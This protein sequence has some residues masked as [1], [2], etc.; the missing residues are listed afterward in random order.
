MLYTS[1]G[2]DVEMSVAST[3][4]FYAQVAAGFLLACGLAEVVGAPG[5]EARSDLLRGLRELPDAMQAVLADAG[6]SPRP[7]SGS[8]PPGGTG[9]S[10]ATGPTASRPRRLRIKLSELCYKSI[11]CD[12]TEDKKHIDLSSEP[13]ILVCAAG[14]SGST[15]DDVAKEVAIY[16]AHKAAPIVIATDGDER[17]AAAQAVISV[18]SVHPSLA[19]VLS[20]MAGHLFGYEAALAIDAQA[21]PL[22]EAR[23]A[24]EAA[25]EAEVER[26]RAALVAHAA[27]RA[28]R[29]G[30]SSTGCARMPTTGT[31]RRAPRCGSHRSCGTRR[32]PCRSTPTRWSTASRHA[33]RRHRGPQQALTRAVEELTRPVDAIKHQAKTVTVGISRSDETLLAVPLVQAVLAAG[34]P[35]DRLGYRT[36]RTLAALDPAIDAVIGFT[37][38]RIDGDPTADQAIIAVVDRGGIGR[39]LAS[40]TER[41]PR[42]RGT[43]RRVAVEREVMA[44]RG[45]S[46]GRTLVIVPEVK[47]SD[48]TGITLLHV[49]WVD[50]LPAATARSV[51]QGYGRYGA[52]VDAVTE[53]EPT[54]RDDLLGSID[55]VDL[56]TESIQR[57]ADRWRS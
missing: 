21:R 23:A 11:A 36:L 52:L 47:G 8:R 35:R 42:L 14:L 9:R 40:R 51:L 27:A 56:L 19:F 28:R 45:R 57:L 7:P 53:T 31:S 44:A 25:V 16:R 30:A 39:D 5:R 32:Q 13:L 55:V 6:R 3:K 22:R 34:A 54:F 37:R 29:R 18:P 20:A 10:S 15:A 1:D 46:D 48:A 12:A 26:R 4:A 2:R 50:R 33:E 17:F 49:R 43:K 24:I 38:Y 41:N